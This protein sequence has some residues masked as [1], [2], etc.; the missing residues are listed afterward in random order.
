MILVVEGEDLVARR[1]QD[2]GFL[3][4]TEVVRVRTAP[5]GDPVVYS[6]R[7][8]LMALRCDEARRVVVQDSAEASP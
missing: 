2:L 5:L 4:G 7:G 6:L 1:L 8:F 3:P